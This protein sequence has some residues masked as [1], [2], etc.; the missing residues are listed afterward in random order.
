MDN[1][2]THTYIYKLKKRE[3]DRVPFPSRSKKLS[4]D[5]DERGGTKRRAGI[6]LACSAAGI[7][8][9]EAAAGHIESS[10]PRRMPATAR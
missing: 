7:F 9:R 5:R 1:T 8:I 3:R 2:H 6:A 10:I 4:R